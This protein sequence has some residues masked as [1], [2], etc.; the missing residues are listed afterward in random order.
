MTFGV[1]GLGRMG[2]GIAYRAMRAG[3]NVVG[4]DPSVS[5][6]EQAQKEGMQTVA[7]L[8]ELAQHAAC[9]WLMVPAGP[10]VDQVLQELVLHVQKGTVIIDGGNSHFPDSIRRAQMLATRGIDYLDCGTSGGVHG[11]EHGFCLMVGGNKEAYEKV[12]HLLKALAVDKGLGLVGP[13]GAGHYVKMIH[14]G[15]E[16]G[17]MQAYAEGFQI[18]KEGS[19]KEHHLD[20][21]A[22][23]D[24]WNHGAVIRSWLLTLSHDI[25]VKDPTL[26]DISGVIQESGTGR[27]T[28]DEAQAHKIP[29]PVIEQSLQVRAESR[30]TGGNFATKVVAMLRNA[31]GAHAVG[32][33]DSSK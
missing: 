2:N 13:S 25:F 18:I 14:N 12:Y 11:K 5:A 24:I 32:K 15:I 22:I 21:A 30:T 31:F 16:Y 27:W 28:V 19:F 29:V 4:F 33:A 7:S 1:V 8:Q 6:R 23:T 10:I 20:L 9:I 17:L 3:H 26:K